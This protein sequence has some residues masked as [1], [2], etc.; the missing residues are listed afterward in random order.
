MRLVVL[1]YSSDDIYSVISGHKEIKLI[2]T[3]YKV[4][5]YSNILK[6]M[7]FI[8]NGAYLKIILFSYYS[9]SPR[10]QKLF[11]I[12]AFWNMKKFQNKDDANIRN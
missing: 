10:L 7:H 4:K 5:T 1:S 3:G 12:H 2:F 6:L 11:V 9:V 8:L